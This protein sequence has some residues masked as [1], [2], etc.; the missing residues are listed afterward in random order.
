MTYPSQAKLEV[1]VDGFLGALARRAA[2]LPVTGPAIAAELEVVRGLVDN[3][4]DVVYANLARRGPVTETSVFLAIRA[5]LPPG[6][7]AFLAVV[8]SVGDQETAIHLERCLQ[9]A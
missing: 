8:Q 6:Y 5:A 2:T 3:Q 1:V 7:G 9:A 4:F